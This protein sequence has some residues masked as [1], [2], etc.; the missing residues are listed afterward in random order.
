M[1][2]L[3]AAV[4]AGSDVGEVGV[5][6]AGKLA[7]LPAVI[8]AAS[9]PRGTGPTRHHESFPERISLRIFKGGGRIS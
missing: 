3:E 2:H 8:T 4:A 7:K 9:P 1:E 5:V 6:K